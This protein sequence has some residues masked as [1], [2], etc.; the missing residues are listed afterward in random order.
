MIAFYQLNDTGGEWMLS[1]ADTPN[2]GWNLYCRLHNWN[3]VTPQLSDPS[4]VM[5]F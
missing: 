4:F 5:L 1:E 3:R 2:G